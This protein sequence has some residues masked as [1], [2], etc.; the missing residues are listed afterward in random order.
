MFNYH[1]IEEDSLKFYQ[2]ADL[3]ELENGEK[4]YVEIG[5]LELVVFNIA[6]E[7]F[8]IGDVCSHDGAPL[9]E[10][11]IEEFEVVCPRHGA[12]FNIRSG[13]ATELPAVEDIPAYPVRMINNQIEV[14][15]P[16]TK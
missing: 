8:A 13:K 12:R 10:G 7:I 2:I 5:D 15:V 9:G 14:G 16:E 1:E 4:L 11:E 6:G 3:S